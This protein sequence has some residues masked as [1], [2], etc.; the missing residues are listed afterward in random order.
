MKKVIATI[1]MATSLV[2]YA[3]NNRSSEV[4]INN[5]NDWVF[6]TD[7]APN[8]PVKIA[9]FNPTVYKLLK[10]C[11]QQV[12]AGIPTVELKM[13]GMVDARAYKNEN[14]SRLIKVF[15]SGNA[16]VDESITFR[17]SCA[18]DSKELIATRAPIGKDT[19]AFVR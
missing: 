3:Q 5:G 7:D 4:L 10:G 6:A 16:V 12:Q 2:A 17:F 8:A 13:V 1:L 15:V 9:S 14:G 11:Y 19:P 18:Y